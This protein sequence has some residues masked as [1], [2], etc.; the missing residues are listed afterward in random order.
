MATTVTAPAISPE[1]NPDHRYDEYIEG[2]ARLMEGRGIPRAAGRIFSFL[3]VML[4]GTVR[5][6]A[7]W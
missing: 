2:F 7:M 4:F 3:S 5:S 1:P 6:P